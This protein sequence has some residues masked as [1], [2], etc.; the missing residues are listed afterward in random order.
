MIASALVIADGPFLQKASSVKS[1]LQTSS[2]MLQLPVAPELP[3]G[4]GGTLTKD[5]MATSKS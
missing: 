2:V 3:T 4:F 1:E 5:G